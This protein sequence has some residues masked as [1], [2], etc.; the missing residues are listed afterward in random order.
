MKIKTV[1]LNH[2]F[3]PKSINRFH[4]LKDVSIELN[5]GEIVTI[6]GK[7]GTGK[8]TLIEHLNALLKPTSG[9]VQFEYELN[10]E[11]KNREIVP[12]KKR[13]KFINEIRKN[14]GIVFQFA[15]YQLFA[16]TILDDIIFGPMNMGV[17]KEE[18]IAKAE[19]VIELVGLDKSYLTRSP[20]ALSGGQKRRVAIAGILAMNPEFIIFDEPT[21][22]LDPSGMVEMYDLFKKINKESN[23]AIIIVT[24]NMDHVLEH[25]Q[26]TIVIGDGEV[27]YYDDTL[28]LMYGTNIL[29]EAELEK[30]KIIRFIDDL[31]KKGLSFNGKPRSIKDLAKAIERM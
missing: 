23:S 26:K 17:S 22:G 9:S 20:F 29:E 19:E 5:Q 4:A 1:K 30:P 27:I 6:I 31:N 12:K 7:S 28:K 2:I 15:E 24:H 14:V 11:N 8:T 3:E 21:A 16:A 10:G 13:Y 25:S 18:S